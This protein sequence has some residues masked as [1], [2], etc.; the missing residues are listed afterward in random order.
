MP[1]PRKDKT[2]VSKSVKDNAFF[3]ILFSVI[4]TAF[5]V[6]VDFILE[7]RVIQPASLVSANMDQATDSVNSDAIVP[8]LSEVTNSESNPVAFEFDRNNPDPQ[9]DF[10]ANKTN[11]IY[12]Q[13]VNLSWNCINA[14]TC[15][16][17]GKDRDIGSVSISS[18][19]GVDII[20][21]KSSSY[22]MT[23]SGNGVSKSFETSIGVFEF[24]IREVSTAN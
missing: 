14:D 9:C 18:K 5:L 20:P 1:R 3:P 4:I 21:K 23:C 15:S 10:R 7:E 19:E 22:V 13:S 17:K 16:I 11:I 8:S 12:G 6:G 24:A 2:K